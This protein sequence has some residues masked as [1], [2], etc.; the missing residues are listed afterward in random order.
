M[1][2]FLK[3]WP[4]SI[5]FSNR[6]FKNI[7]Y[8][9]RSTGRAFLAR[10]THSG[11]CWKKRQLQIKNCPR[12]IFMISWSVQSIFLACFN[13]EF[14]K[15]TKMKVNFIHFQLFDTEKLLYIGFLKSKTFQILYFCWILSILHQDATDYRRLMKS[16]ARSLQTFTNSAKNVAIKVICCM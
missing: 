14:T 8:M 4:F 15:C 6:S 1:Y 2:I 5:S 11:K 3:A 13:S 12:N 10:H 16:L 9:S 7:Q